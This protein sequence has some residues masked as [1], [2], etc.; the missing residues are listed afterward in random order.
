M[1]A[2]VLAAIVGGGGAYAAA[3]PYGIA[4]TGALTKLGMPTSCS[5]Y[6]WDT[7]QPSNP[8]NM[9]RPCKY[10]LSVGGTHQYW[11]YHETTDTIDNPTQFVAWVSAHLGKTWVIGNEPDVGSQDG[12]TTDQYARMFHCYYTFIKPLDPTARFA[13][14]GQS[15]GS[16]AGG[17][18]YATNWYQQALTSYQ[19]Q[20]GTNMPVDVWNV[21]SYCAPLQIEDPDKIVNEFVSPFVQWC[22]TVQGGAYAACPVWI[23]ELP[24]GEWMGALS[25]ENVIYFMQL[26]LPRLE[27]AGMEKWFWYVANDWDGNQGSCSLTDKSGQV[28]SV[29]SAYS[30]LANS[31][32]NAIPA[33][34]PF[35]PYPTPETALFDF[36]GAFGS[37]W[38][39]K[40]GWW[41]NTNGE[42]RHTGIY[43]WPGTGCC[44][45]YTN[46]DLGLSFR[47][48]IN[49]APTNVN[50]A[51]VLLHAASRLHSYTDSGY[52][53]FVRQNGEADLY[54]KVD[55]IVA[56]V[57]GAVADATNYHSYQAYVTGSRITCYIDGVNRID[58]TD[59]NARYTS[60]YVAAQ[61]YKTDSSFDDFALAKFPRPAPVVTDDGV[62]TTN[63]SSLH[64]AWTIADTNQTGFQYSVGLAAGATNVV[65]WTATTDKSVTLALT[66]NLASMYYVNVQAVYPGGILGPMAST[67]GI[68]AALGAV[69]GFGSI[70]VTNIPTLTGDTTND[71]RAIT[72]DGRWVAGIS[73]ARGFLYAV[74]ATNAV[75]V[76]SSDGAQSSV[77]TGV[78]YRTNSSAQQEI[79]VSGTRRRLV[80]QPG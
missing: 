60:G 22:H 47:M 73:G 27:Q 55:G 45:L 12:L 24:I 33:V 14:C 21:H 38:F 76:V 74:N 23:T 15:G 52:L 70:T 13:I 4:G 51:G 58:W 77:V 46:Q 49:S 64:A 11:G 48:K 28:T 78:G 16:T 39:N 29:G 37:P 59:P 71:A 9:V 1:A 19:T 26:Y 40:G 3:N 34:V 56:S 32:T 7:L 75:N 62:Y 5:E 65:P 53:F 68:I 25:P 80:Y 79:I 2:V 63:L 18:T 31:Y 57:P 44:P 17:L 67:D 41:S 54:D 43:P 61:V 30:A 72:P 10:W 69:S 20:F 6:S 66:L 50:W 42:L 8:I 35:V 36:S